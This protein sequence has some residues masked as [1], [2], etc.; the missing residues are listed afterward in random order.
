MNVLIIGSFPETA[1]NR[2][3]ALFPG[4]WT[5]HIAPPEDAARYLP[6]AEVVIPEH[7]RINSEFLDRAPKLRM[8]QTGA[9]YD[10]VD[11]E[12]CTGRGIRVCN[13]A[14]INAQAVAEQTMA[15]LLSYYKNIPCLDSFMKARREEKELSYSGGELA[16]KTVGIIGTGNIGRR[17]A[18]CCQAFGMHV[19]G[20]SRRNDAVSG[21]GMVGLEE[22]LRRSDVI[23]VHVPLTEE[24]RGMLG[25]GEF[26]K[27]KRSAVLINT[28][29]GAVIDEEALAEALRSGRIAG[30]CLDVFEQEPLSRNSPLRDL[31]NV[32][33]TPHTAGFPDGVKYHE[34]RY[35][36]FARNIERLAAG[37]RPE[38]SL[39]EV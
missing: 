13:A 21:I 25:R 31:E 23:S 4:G 6:Q 14:G 3:E 37:Q 34:G 9:G 20:Y 22:L 19:L 2:I 24:T 18:S 30:A 39:N 35:R 11:V 10:N 27:M 33:L 7:I 36:F 1:R 26:E 16:G 8:V 29:R 5:L 15:L 28:S 12:A 17:V 38:H 32:L